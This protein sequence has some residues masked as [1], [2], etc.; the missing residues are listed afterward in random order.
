M[1]VGGRDPMD[2]LSVRDVGYDRRLRRDLYVVANLP[3]ISEA[4]LPGRDHVASQRCR[5]PNG[6]L[7]DDDV[8]LTD[9]DVMGDLN[10]VVDLGPPA[11]ACNPATCPVD[12]IH[13]LIPSEWQKGFGAATPQAA[14]PAA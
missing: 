11:D 3:V 1:M 9:V 7:G 10:E 2:Y 12:R 6:T 4:G 14:V 5:S 13:E 8:I